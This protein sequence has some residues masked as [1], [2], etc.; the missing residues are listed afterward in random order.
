M[1]L[2]AA[3]A[4]FDEGDAVVVLGDD[5]DFAEATMP[6][7]GDDATTLFLQVKTGGLFGGLATWVGF[8]GCGVGSLKGLILG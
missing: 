8:H 1:A 3:V 5:V 4:H 2:A 6:V 7:A